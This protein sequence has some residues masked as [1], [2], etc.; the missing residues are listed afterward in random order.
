MNSHDVRRQ[1]ADQSGAYSPEY[2][3]HHGPDER[4]EAVRE[5]LDET[6]GAGASVLE[7]GCSSG[8]HLQHLFANGY[9]DLTGIELNGDA[10]D[11]MAE[12]YPALAET[13]TIHVGAMEDVLQEVDDDAFDAIFAVETLQH[14]HPDATWVFDEIAR[15]TSDALVV[16]ENEGED[17]PDREAGVTDVDGFPL[18][19]RDWESIFTDCGLNSVAA[20]EGTRDTIRLFRTPDHD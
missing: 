19:F 1:W 4:S 9:D 15:V 12:T 6:V 8:R 3:A 20:R 18:Y 13:A 17:H 5:H 11:V 2:Y 16:I 7:L 14:V 10:V